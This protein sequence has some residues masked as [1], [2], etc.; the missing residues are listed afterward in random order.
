MERLG[1][2]GELLVGRVLEAWPR[3][4][5]LQ[6]HR[7]PMGEALL[8]ALLLARG[9]AGFSDADPGQTTEGPPFLREALARVF[10]SQPQGPSAC[11]VGRHWPPDLAAVTRGL[12]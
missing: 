6:T 3:G 4:G 9:G 8:Q 5:S 11:L 10:C 2:T 7:H 1:Q 12:E